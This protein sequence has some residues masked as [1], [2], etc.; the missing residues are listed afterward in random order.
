[1]QILVNGKQM[2]FDSPPSGS[3]LLAR[4]NI[5]PATVVAELNGEIIKREEFLARM[6]AD[7]DVLEL[8]T[9]VGGG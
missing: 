5:V 6:L 3:D 9:V 4:L 7:G 2:E 1:M 8:V